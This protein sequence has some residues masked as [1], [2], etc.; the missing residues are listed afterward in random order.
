MPPLS[1][2]GPTIEILR[3]RFRDIIQRTNDGDL[4]PDLENMAD[5]LV[6][7]A[8]AVLAEVAEIDAFAELFTRLKK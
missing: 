7:A 5:A 3:G 6:L 1:K 4:T 8:V 2:A